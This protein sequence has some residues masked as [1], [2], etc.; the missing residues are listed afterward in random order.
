MQAGV[1]TEKEEEYG[2]NNDVKR[3]IAGINRHCRKLVKWGL[4][5]KVFKIHDRD[6]L[7]LKTG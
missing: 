7:V 6:G 3:E 4:Y 2:N 5:G 1:K